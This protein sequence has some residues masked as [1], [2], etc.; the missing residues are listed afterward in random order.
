MQWKAES[1][2]AHDLEPVLDLLH[3]AGLPAEGVVETFGHYVVVRTDAVVVGAAG[4][5]VC[6][7]DGLLR[8]VAVEPSFRGQGIGA[9]LVSGVRDL[10]VHLGLRGLYLLT[11]TAPG[12]FGRYGFS[13][14]P[15]GEA[16]AA[17]GESWEFKTGCPE[18]ATFMRLGLR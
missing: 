13:P 11:T 1:A 5:E 7:E 10:A 18:S 9:G 14:C 12:Y 2:R 6:G 8:S 17:I 15:R 4:L 3:R 16:P